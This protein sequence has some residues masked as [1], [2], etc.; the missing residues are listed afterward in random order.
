MDRARP[1]E[2]ETG[3]RATDVPGQGFARRFPSGGG[4]AGAGEYS[5]GRESLHHEAERRRAD[6]ASVEEGPA[7]LG[8][9]R[10]WNGDI[11]RSEAEG[12]RRR[13]DFRRIRSAWG[14]NQTIGSFAF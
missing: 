6:Q 14:S 12:R 2:S 7:C 11:E 5:S 3:I 4:S 8:A 13:G 10:A 1:E 9:S